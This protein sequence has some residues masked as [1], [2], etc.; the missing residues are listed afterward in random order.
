MLTPEQR[1]ERLIVALCNELTWGLRSFHAA[2]ALHKNEL[3]LTPTLFDTFYWSCLDNS[4]LILSRIVVAKKKFKEDAVNVQYLLEQAKNHPSLFRF[5]KLDEI[6]KLIISQIELLEAYKPV[7]EV[8]E[9]QRDRN[10]THLDLKHVK[11]PEWREN[12][13]QLDLSRVEQLYQDLTDVMKN[14][15]LLFFGGELDFGDWEKVS[16]VEIETLI[17]FYKARNS[18]I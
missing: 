2:K 1:M 5:A 12:Q 14:Y 8:L 6:Q 11:Q 15:H 4:A 9:D 13:A 7:I 18:K 10:L 3:R 17:E 16:Q